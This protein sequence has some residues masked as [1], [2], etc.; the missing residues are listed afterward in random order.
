MNR[1]QLRILDVLARDLG[2][3]IPISQLTKRIRETH[4]STYYANVH[5][6]L[7]KL[8]DDNAVSIEKSGRSSLVSINLDTSASIDLLAEMELTLKRELSREQPEF[9]L[10]ISDLIDLLEQFPVI[11]SASLIDPQRNLK[12]NRAEMFVILHDG[13]DNLEARGATLGIL[14]KLESQHSLRIDGLILS[15]LEVENL[16]RSRERN[17]LREM[18]S[19]KV[20]VY[21]PQAFWTLMRDL[22]KRGLQVRFDRKETHP[23]KLRERDVVYNLA[24][25]GYKEMGPTIDEGQSISSE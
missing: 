12:L 4:S 20:V 19:Q 1:T 22:W 21:A 5:R 3:R 15:K 16:L 11:S 7:A 2:N 23:A 18:L 17:P 8:K 6:A 13:I 24:R 14:Q 10:L 25:F 9:E